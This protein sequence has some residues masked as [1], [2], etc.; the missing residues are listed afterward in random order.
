MPWLTARQN[1]ALG[2]ERVYPHASKGERRD[3]VDLYDPGLVK[4]ALNG[5]FC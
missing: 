5:S 1:V 3:I 4:I 2:V